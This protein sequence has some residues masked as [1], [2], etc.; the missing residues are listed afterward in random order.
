LNAG[1]AH[2]LIANKD[3]NQVRKLVAKLQ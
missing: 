1:R 3:L 2:L